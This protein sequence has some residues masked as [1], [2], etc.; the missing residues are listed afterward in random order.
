MSR[1]RMKILLQ[2]GLSRKHSGVE[3]SI[4]TRFP[5]CLKVEAVVKK[6]TEVMAVFF[7]DDRF[8]ARHGGS[9]ISISAARARAPLIPGTQR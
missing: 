4:P 9:L 1:R 6:K 5:A 2:V 8:S 7:A 3:K